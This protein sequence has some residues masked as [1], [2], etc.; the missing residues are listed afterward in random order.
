MYV[1]HNCL[2]FLLV[3]DTLI[4]YS[5]SAASS[6]EKVGGACSCN[7]PTEGIM[8][9][10]NFNFSQT[11][12]FL[13]WVGF[14]LPQILNYPTKIL[15]IRIFSVNFPTAP[16]LGEGRNYHPLLSQPTSTQL[17]VCTLGC[18]T[19][20]PGHI[21]PDVRGKCPRRETSAVD[22]PRG[23]CPSPVHWLVNVGAA[24]HTVWYVINMSHCHCDYYYIILSLYFN[25][26]Q[27]MCT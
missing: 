16:I 2:Y 14:F 25:M 23:K 6:I 22:R 13:S 4:L 15:E 17:G 21:P 24:C 27:Y 20:P 8:G 10:Q 11:W 12:V 9:A 19:F 18:R 1:P 5:C 26:F 7:F 3:V